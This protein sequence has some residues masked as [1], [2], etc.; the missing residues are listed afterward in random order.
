[1]HQTVWF[2]KR[3]SYRALF[4]FAAAFFSLAFCLCFVTVPFQPAIYIAPWF[5]AFVVTIGLIYRFTRFCSSCDRVLNRNLIDKPAWCRCGILVEPEQMLLGSPGEIDL[6]KPTWNEHPQPL[7]QL[8]GML[9]SL[10]VQ[11]RLEW[12]R[13]R[14]DGTTFVKEP[15]KEPYEMVPMPEH[16]VPAVIQ[17]LRAMMKPN[18][19]GQLKIRVPLGNGEPV[20][21]PAQVRVKET[22]TGKQV[23]IS[24]EPL[25]E[26]AV[27][28][29]AE[30]NR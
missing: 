10:M 24:M 21:V 8:I 13:I 30:S 28:A 6:T 12:L 15:D 22:Q 17:V 20:T 23:L 11:G 25:P 2:E 19:D 14:P 4:I 27:L 3:P 5:L 18:E 7:S 1:M 9:T 16:L 29:V 26:S